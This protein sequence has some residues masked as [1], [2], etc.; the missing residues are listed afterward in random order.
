MDYSDLEFNLLSCSWEEQLFTSK[1]L[2]NFVQKR[3]MLQQAVQAQKATMDSRQ[4]RSFQG[5]GSQPGLGGERQV[6]SQ[7]NSTTI[8]GNNSANSQ[9]TAQASQAILQAQKISQMHSNAKFDSGVSLF[10]PINPDVPNNAVSNALAERSTALQEIRTRLLDT[11]IRRNSFEAAKSQGNDWLNSL[12][13]QK[14]R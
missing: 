4:P 10:K 1:L 13:F 2:D 11:F 12:T 3:R 14:T 5:F 6:S 8:A 7:S 9:Q